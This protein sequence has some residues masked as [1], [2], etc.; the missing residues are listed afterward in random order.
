MKKQNI[1]NF[2]GSVKIA[3]AVSALVAIQFAF[4]GNCSAQEKQDP[5]AESDVIKQTLSKIRDVEQLNT[6]QEQNK[7]LKSENGKLKGEIA[8]IK[9][10]LAKLTQDLAQQTAKLRKQLLQMPTFE[11]QSKVL[12]GGKSMAL[13]KSKDKVIRIRDNTEMSVAVADGVWVLMQ[14]K[15]ISKDMIELHFPELERTVYLYD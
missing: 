10:Q 13:L 9:K 14:V 12:G 6:F 3:F 11:V 5:T 15:K 1:A 4:A 8:S 7:A 2:F